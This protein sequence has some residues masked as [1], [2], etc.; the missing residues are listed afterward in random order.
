[1]IGHYPPTQKASQQALSKFLFHSPSHFSRI[2]LGNGASELIDLLIRRSTPG[3]FHTGPWDVQYKEFERSVAVH[4]RH[5][6]IKWD[7]KEKADLICMVNPCNPTGQYMPVDA[8][9]NWLSERINDHGTIIVD[10][11]MQPWVGRNFR[12]DSL[13][14]QRDFIVTMLESRNVQVF[15]IHS[16][17]KIWCCP[18]LRLG[19]CVAPTEAIASQCR[20]LQVPWSVNVMALSFLNNVVNDTKYLEKT[21]SETCVFR[22]DQCEAISNAMKDV[23]DE[24]KWILK[25][26]MF[27]SWIWIDTRSVEV[28]TKA[29]KLAAEAG[30]PIRP[31]VHGYDRPTFIRIAVRQ[32]E[33][34]KHLMEAIEPIF[35][36][37]KQ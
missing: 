35:Q 25:G 8:L 24:K 36:E 9:T 33:H 22:K 16:W 20:T 13:L 37:L 18:G 28:A 29:V 30:T 1:M 6:Q 19:S 27:N 2:L 31:G 5:R 21:W 32:P 17:T 23:P 7:S 3:T 12:Q 11:S 34:F 4:G 26:E 10:E 14:S 15:V